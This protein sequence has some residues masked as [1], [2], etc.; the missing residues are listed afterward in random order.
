M[1][2]IYCD[3][4]QRNDGIPEIGT[5]ARDSA[6]GDSEGEYS[7]TATIIDTVRY[8]K[9]EPGREYTVKGKLMDADTGR[10]LLIDGREVTSQKTFV[11]AQYDGAI[12]IEFTVDSTKLSGK[13]VVVFEE[14]YRYKTKVAAHADITDRGQTITFPDVKTEAHSVATGSH[15][16]ERSE[17]AVIIDTVSYSNLIPGKTYTLTGTLMNK[18]TGK[19]IEQNGQEVTVS[20]E[21]T[22]EAADGTAQMT[23]E[24]DSTVL[25]GET[26]V[27][28]EEL[29]RNGVLVGC[30]A[31]ITDEG[32]SIYFP[33]ISTTAM[34][35]ETKDNQGHTAKEV[36]VIDTV[37][38]EN[39]EAGREYRLTGVIMDKTKN[40]PLVNGNEVITS[41]MT[42]T[43]ERSSGEVQMNFIVDS[44]LLEGTTTVVFENLYTEDIE[45]A[46]HADIDDEGQSVHWSTIRT[47][48]KDSKTDSRKGTLSRF[49]KIVDTVTYTNLIPGKEYTVKGILMDKETGKPVKVKGEYVTAEKSFVPKE[50]DGTVDIVFHLDS[51][52]L[53][54]KTVVV[55]EDLYHNGVLI[56]SHADIKDKAQSITYPEKPEPVISIPKTGDT[57][58]I[59]AYAGIT[60]A[61]LAAALAM[62]VRIRRKNAEDN[63]D[64]IE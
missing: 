58:N 30:H 35:S 40:A 11:A 22:P 63:D 56:T 45:L 33:E 53:D 38:Y 1:K 24:V 13:T 34:D 54:E 5:T 46:V 37:K 62:A 15:M 23:F 59:L 9:L 64:D 8:E 3:M 16:G 20:F 55:F 43:P 10:P 50:A 47:S 2:V 60:L 17:K 19:P 52:E 36:T 12:D 57:T 41:E 26:V 25:A 48:A 49:D 14:L 51:R 42:F 4:E 18:A 61:S 28:F 7:K 39:L 21:F 44:T 6:T 32:Q 31:D 29:H 27:V